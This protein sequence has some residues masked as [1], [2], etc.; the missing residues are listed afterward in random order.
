[1]LVKAGGTLCH[2]CTPGPRPLVPIP[3]IL[4]PDGLLPPRPG[5][6]PWG[7]GVCT[8][9]CLTARQACA[10]GPFHIPRLISVVT[11]TGPRDP[12]GPAQGAG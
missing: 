1:M 2:L 5:W 4:P 12:S 11:A 10:L 7:D 6:S 3:E 9:W 8:R